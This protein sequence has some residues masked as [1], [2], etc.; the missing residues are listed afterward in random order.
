[1]RRTPFSCSRSSRKSA[2]FWAMIPPR[3]VGSAVAC[4]SL[5]RRKL[6]LRRAAGAGHRG[7]FGFDEIGRLGCAIRLVLQPAARVALARE[8]V[9]VALLLRG[10]VP[11]FSLPASEP[12]TGLTR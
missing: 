1:M 3:V 9:G 5:V 12:R 8:R 11:L 2:V 10:A 4:S 6:L 7:A